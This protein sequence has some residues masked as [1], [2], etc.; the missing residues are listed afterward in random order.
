[1]EELCPNECGKM[2]TVNQHIETMKGDTYFN[3]TV[4]Y[5]PDCKYISFVD[6]S[7]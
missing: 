1:M 6:A 2:E 7:L 4:T 3:V 5:C